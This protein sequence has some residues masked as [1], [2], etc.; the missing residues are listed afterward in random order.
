MCVCVY[1]SVCVR[2]SMDDLCLCVYLCMHVCKNLFISG[3]G[4]TAYAADTR[5]GL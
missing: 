1:M 5:G 3:L 4:Q 2:V